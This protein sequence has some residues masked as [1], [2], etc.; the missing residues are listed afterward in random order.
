MPRK[1]RFKRSRLISVLGKQVLF[2][3]FSG[4]VGFDG[5]SCAAMKSLDAGP[6]VRTS[7]AVDSED[8]LEFLWLR[9]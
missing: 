4:C 1:P 9:L 2:H 7:P 3:A 6:V 5:V 8:R